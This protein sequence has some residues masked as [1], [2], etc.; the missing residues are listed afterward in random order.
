[1]G[2]IFVTLPSSFFSPLASPNREYYAACLL[3][4]Y[5]AFQEGTGGVERSTA[6][7]RFADYIGR[8]H[9]GLTLEP[10]MDEDILEADTPPLF[11]EAGGGGAMDTEASLPDRSRVIATRFIRTLVSAGWIG[12]ETLPDYSRVL[13]MTPFAKPFFEAL[14]RID[15]GLRVEYESH[16]VA[17]YSLLS[18]DASAENGHYVVLNAHDHTMALIDSLKVLSQSIKAHHETFFN[19][20][21]RGEVKDLLHLHYDVYAD[22]ILDG[23]Y[24]R[25]KTSDNLSR[26]RPKIIR[27]GNDLLS[28][29]AWL[30]ASSAKL[31]RMKSIDA[32]SAR[33]ELIMML[34]EI[35]DTLKAV[36]PLLEDIDRRNMMYAS[37]SIERIKTMLQSDATIAGRIA[38]AAKCIRSDPGLASRLGHKMFRVRT[39]SPESRYRR[40]L[41]D[42]LNLAPVARIS[43][44]PADLAR[45]E[46]ELRL[47]IEAQLGP[48]KIIAWLDAGGGEKGP[49]RLESIIRD[50]DSFVRALYA[51]LYAD[52]GLE[53][54]PY[55]LE[56]GHEERVVVAGYEIPDLVLRRKL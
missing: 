51:V 50:T 11:P 4:F 46:A 1:M 31:A 12:E 44:D 45:I 53:R 35:R 49:L 10:E 56:E 8:N 39:V 13:N 41:R 26:Y 24:K 9:D 48:D 27:R 29:T 20:S 40:W 18:G 55:Q 38:E 37:A 3:I 36:D 52:S 14:S 23:A 54:F 33:Q 2:S 5:R 42:T 7:S 32:A 34:E 22:E 19:S 47:R 30:D 16:V 15:E 28:D 25:L 17:I 21:A 43:D 6:V